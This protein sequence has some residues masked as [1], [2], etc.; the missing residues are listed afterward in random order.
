MTLTSCAMA[1]IETTSACPTMLC[2]SVPT[3]TAS[4]SVYVSSSSRGASSNGRPAVEGVVG[5]VVPDV[6]LVEADPDVALAAGRRPDV[7]D[8]RGD[9][10]EE[11]V[12]HVGRAQER[13][14]VAVVVEVDVARE[15]VDDVDGAGQ[16]VAFPRPERA[17]LRVR[18]ADHHE[19]ERRVEHPHRRCRRRGP[20]GVVV[21]PSGARAATARRPRCRG[22]TGA[23]RA[24]RPPRC[25]RARRTGVVPPGWFAYSSSCRA[26]RVSPRPRLRASIGSTPACRHHATNSSV[27]K[28]LDSTDRHARSSRRGRASRGPMPSRQSYPETKLP[29]G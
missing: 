24:A 20:L 18:A 15:V 27:P 11:P 8:G 16:H 1:A 28:A 4:A 12:E 19:L 17:H 7:R 21:A 13:T 9:V 6:P 25:A 29:P 2:S 14:Q 22:T 3:T 5:G 26:E 10:V 23:R